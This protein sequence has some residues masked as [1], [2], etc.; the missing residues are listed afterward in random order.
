M[1]IF[2]PSMMATLKIYTGPGE[3]SYIRERLNSHTE[4]K[5]LVVPWR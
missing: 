5:A 3:L 1:Y 2:I 4:A